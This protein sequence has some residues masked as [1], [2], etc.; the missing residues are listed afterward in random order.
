[1][2]FA[3]LTQMS[4]QAVT[5]AQALARHLSHNEVD[6]WHL[7]SAL[8]AQENGIVP[9]LVEKLGLTVSALQLA[10]DRELEKLP[11]V[12]GSVDT[13]KVYVTQAVNDVLTR[14]EDEAK[15]LKDE[16]VSVEHLLLG[17]IEVGKPDALKKLFQSFGLD[18]AK[19][20]KTLKEIRGSQ[21]VTTDNPEATYEALEK[22]GID[23]VAQARK[24]KM[25]PVIGRDEEIRRTI[26]ILSRKTKNNPVLIGEPGVGKTAIVE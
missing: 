10:V 3:K 5:D 6:T 24:G 13:S 17:L 21:R 9:G 11:K 1:M 18:R 25:D 16:Y 12:T 19:V 14:A 26:R 22:Y 15:S 2:D 8:L 23:L 4:R 20:L 7:L